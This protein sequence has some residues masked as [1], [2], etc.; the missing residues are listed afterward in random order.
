MRRATVTLPDELDQRLVAF[1]AAQPGRPT[2]T[3]VVEA[4]L[5]Q[6]LA[7][8]TAD[9]SR[10]VDVLRRR[11][12]I[13]EAA[14]TLGALR[15]GVFGSVARADDGPDSDVDF[16]IDSAPGTTLFHLAALRGRLAELLACEVDLVT[17]SSIPPEDRDA[18]LASSVVL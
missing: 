12:E 4:A 8:G 9:R 16:W 13:V 7:S 10:I 1:V 6:Y 18:V 3:S 14:R 15:I 17:L 5:A 2:F 11:E